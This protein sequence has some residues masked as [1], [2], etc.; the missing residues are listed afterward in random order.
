MPFS[1]IGGLINHATS[2]TGKE[3]IAKAQELIKDRLYF[4]NLTFAPTQHADIH[5]FTIDQVLVYVNFYSDFGPNNLSHVMRFC[6][7]LQGKFR[8]PATSNKKICLYSSM[9][10]DKRAN[11][12]FLICAYMVIV[13][14]QTP[15]DAYR[16]F[17][18]ISPPFVPYCDAGYGAA[19]YHI[20]ILDCIRGLHKA[21]TLGL[22]DL[23]NLNLEEYEYYE[24]VENGDFNWITDKFLALASPKDDPSQFLVQQS[25]LLT[26]QQQ[27][28]IALYNASIGSGIIYPISVSIQKQLG[29]QQS[30]Q[31]AQAEL[32]RRQKLFSAYSMDNLIRYMKEKNIKTI[33]RLNNK[34]YDKRK[35]VLAGIEHIELYF[36]DGTTPPEGILKRFLEI[37]ETRE[38]PIAVHCKAGLGRTGS[39]IASF[40]MKHY[41]MTACE[42]ISFMRVL[43]PGSVVGPQQN[44]LQAMQTKLWKMHPNNPLSTEILCR[45]VPTY[46]NIKRFGWPIFNANGSVIGVAQ[47]PQ[48]NAQLQQKRFMSNE[49]DGSSPTN[50]NLAPMELDNNGNYNSD[51]RRELSF[52]RGGYSQVDAYEAELE[53]ERQNTSIGELLIPVQPRKAQPGISSTTTN[54][55]QPNFDIWR[56]ASTTNQTQPQQLHYTHARHLSIENPQLQGSFGQ[57]QNNQQMRY[58]LRSQT[59]INGTTSIPPNGTN[60]HIP[61]SITQGYEHTDASEAA[62]MWGQ[63]NQAQEAQQILVQDQ[64][65]DDMAGFVLTGGRIS[66]PNSGGNR[67]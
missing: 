10:N 26:P 3:V 24:K 5:F 22:L 62:K 37:C 38:G 43:R 63:I 9:D 1:N 11:A 57:V 16:P 32:T 40:I 50:A 42:V 19:T 59:P 41:K 54:R 34:T 48:Q 55:A 39:L 8:D 64:R 28:Q 51:S 58:N 13:Q 45:K 52:I 17:M 35:F 2:A 61:R 20:T 36:P 18:S 12:V 27:Q 47:P 21:L 56:Q 33:I 14:N 30:H 6:E 46:P 4:T 60:R 23:E 49:L 65:S 44:Y 31:Q 66:T 25:A 67:K 53:R 29:I 7:V 15:E